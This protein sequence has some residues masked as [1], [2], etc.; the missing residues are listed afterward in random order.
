MV[1]DC[2]NCPSGPTSANRVMIT[3]SN[4]EHHQYKKAKR[5]LTS[6]LTKTTACGLQRLWF[7]VEEDG[8]TENLVRSLALSL[9]P[10]S[11]I[12]QKLQLSCMHGPNVP[13]PVV[14]VLTRGLRCGIGKLT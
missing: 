5:S 4:K 1:S 14:R 9:N 13:A 10:E 8:D 11:N 12:I 2:R 6:S 7:S 3:C